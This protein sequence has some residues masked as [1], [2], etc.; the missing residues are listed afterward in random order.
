LA[1]ALRFFSE[2][3]FLL[4]PLKTIEAKCALFMQYMY[5]CGYIKYSFRSI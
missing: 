5:N 2:V 4:S 1:I 3:L